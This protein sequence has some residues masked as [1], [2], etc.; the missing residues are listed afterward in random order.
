MGA[1]LDLSSISPGFSNPEMASQ[2][3]FRRSLE[4]LSRPGSV[5]EVQSD[6]VAPVGVGVAACALLL[7]LP[8]QDTRV[9]LAPSVSKEAAA[10]WRFHT[11][12][13]I[14]RVRDEADF[15]LVNDVAE[16]PLLQ[17][18]RCGSDEYPH[19]SA[20]LIVEVPHL[21]TDGGWRITGPGIRNEARLSAPAL[22]K[23]FAAQWAANHQLFPRGIDIFFTCGALLCGLPRTIQL[24]EDDS[25]CM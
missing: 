6:A 20:T 25:P 5:I 24:G 14:T 22:G 1:C 13:Q 17:S 23:H 3:V 21:A 11:G 4:A 15:A 19:L 8:E 12:C 16:M 10:Y 9:W 7:A 2:A 18:L